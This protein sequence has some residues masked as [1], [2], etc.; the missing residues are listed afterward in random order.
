MVPA[1]ALFQI[2]CVKTFIK[3]SVRMLVFSV[4][5]PFAFLEISFIFLAILPSVNS[6]A[7]RQ[8]VCKLSL[9]HISVGE[10]ISA[11]ASF[12]G[13][14]KKTFVKVVSHNL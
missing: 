10:D 5:M 13:T 12:G 9:V 6:L 11:C 2:I 3:V 14:H 1:F 7:M 8:I 4:A